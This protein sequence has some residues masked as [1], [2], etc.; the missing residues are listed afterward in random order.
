MAYKLHEKAKTPD[1]TTSSELGTLYPEYGN[2]SY[3]D[4]MDAETIDKRTPIF[5]PDTGIPKGD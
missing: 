5:V 1:V 3:N 2:T 4:A